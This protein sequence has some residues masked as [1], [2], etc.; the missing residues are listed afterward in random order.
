[1]AAYIIIEGPDGAG[2]TTLIEKLLATYSD[3]KYLHFGVPDDYTKQFDIYRH[4]IAENQHHS[5][6]IFD[7][8]WYSDRVYAP[9]MRQREEMSAAQ[10]QM[11]EG[12]VQTYG[13]GM[14]IYLTA[15]TNTLWERCTARGE[16]YIQSTEQLGLIS[17]K[18]GEVMQEVG[19]PMVIMHTDI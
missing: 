7:R 11:L 16:T 9:V 8:C 14:I 5:V 18:Y 17:E 3:A 15:R 2:K 13:G 6:V 10:V 4:A 12:I 19:L 1:M